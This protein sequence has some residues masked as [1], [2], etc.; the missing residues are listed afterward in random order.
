MSNARKK[1]M[2]I[3]RPAFLFLESHLLFNLLSIGDPLLDLCIIHLCKFREAASSNHPSQSSRILSPDERIL[4][5]RLTCSPIAPFL[6]TEADNT[7]V[8]LNHCF[9][10]TLMHFTNLQHS[11]LAFRVWSTFPSI[12]SFDLPNSPMR[13]TSQS[14]YPSVTDEQAQG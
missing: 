1:G 10:H 6:S 3:H 8:I 14:C 12:G 7:N 13:N 5:Q 11:G 4:N 9:S 2:E